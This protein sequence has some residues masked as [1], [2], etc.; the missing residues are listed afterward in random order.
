VIVEHM[1]A[2]AASVVNTS[3]A[4]DCLVAGCLWGLL[5]GLPPVHALACGMV[6]HPW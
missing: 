6:S 4:G 5:Q 2:P 1:A 3:G